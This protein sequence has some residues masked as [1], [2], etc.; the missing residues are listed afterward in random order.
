MTSLGTT[1]TQYG[2]AATGTGADE[3]TMGALAT[4]DGR[5]IGTFHDWNPRRKSARLQPVSPILV[6]Q[7]LATASRKQSFRLWITCS[8]FD[9]IHGFA[10][11]VLALF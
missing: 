11:P 9:R 2:T 4:H 1:G 3:E 5:L 7:F 8:D 10:M 6:K